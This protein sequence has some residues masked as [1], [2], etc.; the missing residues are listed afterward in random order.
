VSGYSQRC[1]VKLEAL[2]A[3]RSEWICENVETM[4]DATFTCELCDYDRIKYV[5]VM[6]HPQW[7]GEFRVGCVC[8]GTMSGN[9]LAAQERDDAAKRRESRKRAFMKKQWVEHPAR[10]MVLPKTRK[11]ITAEI[12]SFCGREFY[13]VIIDGEPYQ[14]WEN[15]RIE[16][17]DAAKVVAFE[18]L[19]YERKTD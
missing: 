5:H 9:M 8:D 4:E 6:V 2:G 16:T 18:V 11:T 15:R 13:K 1:I 17:L 3:P 14:W 7:N 10:F 19:E 12:D